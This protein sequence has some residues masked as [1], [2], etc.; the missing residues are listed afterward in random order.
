M[1]SIKKLFKEGTFTIKEAY[2]LY[3]SI[4][5][6]F[7]R[8]GTRVSGR[9]FEGYEQLYYRYGTAEAMIDDLILMTLDIFMNRNESDIS[10]ISNHKVKEIMLYI[11]N[12]FNQEISIQQLANQFF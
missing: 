1:E 4:L 9:F 5:Y 2:L 3:T 11:R 8:E 12:H 7:P 6:L 10:R